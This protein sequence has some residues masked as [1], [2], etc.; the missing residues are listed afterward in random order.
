MTL[1]DLR[2]EL[3]RINLDLLE[4]LSRRARV[5]EQV[6]TV[7]ERDGIPAHVPE[8][9]QAMLDALVAANRGPFPEETVRRLFR[10][11][12]QASLALQETG[13]R[14]A[15]KVSRASGG[16]GRIV[17]IGGVPIGGEPVVIAG[18]CA[19]EDEAQLD[20][21]GRRLHE[22]G[23]PLL[24]GGAF[25][26]RSSPYAFQGL[27]RRGLEILRDTGR[28]HGLAVVTEVTDT[29][30][31]E[32]VAE[33]ADALQIGSRNMHNY[34]LLRE[35]G[36]SGKPVLLKRGLAATLEELL[37]AAEYVVLQG[38]EQ[39]IL[40]ERGIRTFC[41]D[42]RNTLDIS[43]V[44]LLRQRTFL[45]VVVDVSHAAGRRDILAPLGRAALAAGA[46][47]LMVEV[48]PCPAVARSD[49]QQ[50]LDFDAFRRFV[51]DVGLSRP[52]RCVA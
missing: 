42:T 49:S 38:N 48:H 14:Q 11:I 2:E 44:A 26:A 28:R 1:E 9:E 4:L 24:R 10:E 12:F 27:G 46:G 41:N 23:V 13:R 25:K 37:W 30:L 50:Q 21:V 16:P 47:G 7:K 40:C 35:A 45:P 8:R 43:A 51:R 18:P 22:L 17:R 52:A 32:L 3:Q 31:V 20:A 29:R 34:E 36:R 5:V 33:H 39:V 19:V 15:L 6:R